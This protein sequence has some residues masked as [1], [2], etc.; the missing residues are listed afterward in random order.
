MLMAKQ[1]IMVAMKSHDDDNSDMAMILAVPLV[2][3]R[4]MMMIAPVTIA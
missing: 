4:F 2:T 3:Q 1:P